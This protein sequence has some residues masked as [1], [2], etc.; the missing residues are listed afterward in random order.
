MIALK[1]NEQET[2]AGDGISVLH[3]GDRGPLTDNVCERLERWGLEVTEISSA[4][5]GDPRPLEAIEEEDFDIA[6]LEQD[7]DRAFTNE[8]LLNLVGRGKRVVL[9]GDDPDAVPPEI[10][11]QVVLTSWNM[12]ELRGAIRS[13]VPDRVAARTKLDA[14]RVLHVGNRGPSTDYRRERLERLDLD[15]LEVSSAAEPDHAEAAAEAAEH[16]DFELAIVEM[17][18]DFTTTSRVLEILSSRGKPVIL[19]TDDPDTRPP[20][21][22]P[23]VRLSSTEMEEVRHAI[24]STL[25]GPR[26]EHTK[27]DAVR[28]LHVG[29][30]GP[31]TDYTH[32]YLDA[33][34]LDVIEVSSWAGYNHVEMAVEA[35]AHEYF[36][37]AIIE[38][39]RDPSVTREILGK[40]AHRGEPI[41]LIA[42]NT[43]AVPDA[44]KPRVSLMSGEINEIREAIRKVLPPSRIAHV[45]I[46]ADVRIRWNGEE[47]EADHDE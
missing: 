38:E 43:D 11:R 6:I 15:V 28:V 9:I 26:I 2:V 47:P 25:P 37:L 42:N 20:E 34:G 12:D 4:T 35:A 21:I 33:L 39:D 8:L 10:K 27:L 17:D 13:M 46:D 1:A 40:L 36:E 5:R 44:I 24:R 45:E 18:R 16:G 41:I 14:V 3:I 30:H 32:D 7:R 22:N 29:D 31:D 23:A 19:I